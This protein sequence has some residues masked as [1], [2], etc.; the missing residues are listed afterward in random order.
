MAASAD[1]CPVDHRA[2]ASSSAEKCPVDH[3]QRSSWASILGRQSENA[4]GAAELPDT[5]LPP[6]NL[7]LDRETS[8]IPRIDGG[9]WVYPSQA[10]FYAAMARKNHNPQE[11][12]MKVV[13]P[14]HNA[15][16]ER[17][18]TEIMKWEAGQGGDKCGGVKL[19]SFKGRPNER[20]PRAWFYSLL[21]YSPPFDRHDWI[22][23]RCGTR[24]RYVIDFYSG[25]TSGPPSKNLSFF[26]DVRPALDSWDGVR[27]RTER[28]WG[29]VLGRLWG[30]SVQPDNAHPRS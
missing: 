27:L 9:N 14:I 18:W 21:G 29:R 8:S 19:V 3:T 12:D 13:V 4:H 2:L 1:K 17:A 16:N 28:F 30:E 10:Q 22:I 23:D 20:T 15:V 26:L 11:T 6:T 24:T 7:P 25:R 5:P